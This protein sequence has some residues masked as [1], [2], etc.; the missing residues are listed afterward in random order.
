MLID[1]KRPAVSRTYGSENHGEMEDYVEK[2]LL[3]TQLLFYLMGGLGMFFLGV[4]ALWFVSLYK[5]K[6]GRTDGEGRGD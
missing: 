2:A 5:D 4:G 6:K 3:A 1:V